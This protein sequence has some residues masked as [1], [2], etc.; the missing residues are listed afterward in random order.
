MPV[1]LRFTLYLIYSRVGR[2]T[3][4]TKCQHTLCPAFRLL[5]SRRCG[6]LGGARIA[7]VVARAKEIAIILLKWKSQTV[8]FIGGKKLNHA[9][10]TLF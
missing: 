6:L 8:G 4:G 9:G 1:L 5:L 7:Y 10:V 3:V 2:G